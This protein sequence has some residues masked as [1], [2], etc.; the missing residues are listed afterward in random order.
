MGQRRRKNLI[1]IQTGCINQFRVFNGTKRGNAAPAITRVSRLHIG[2][3]VAE[4]NG[5]SC[6][7]QLIGSP[8]CAHLDIR[9]NKKLKWR[10]R[11]HQTADITTVKNRAMAGWWVA[12]KS[13]LQAQKAGAHCRHGCDHGCHP[14]HAVITDC[15]AVD[16]FEVQ[17]GDLCGGAV[18]LGIIV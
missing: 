12:G 1:C 9:I 17:R 6:G 8:L 3:N 16:Q 11:Q 5:L 13:A 15:R 4:H 7:L 18:F 14:G 2:K 10:I